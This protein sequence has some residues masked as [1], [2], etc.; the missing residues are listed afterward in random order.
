MLTIMFNSELY[1]QQTVSRVFCSLLTLILIFVCE[2][3]PSVFAMIHPQSALLLQRV[4]PIY[5]LI[6]SNHVFLPH[7]RPRHAFYC[8]AIIILIE[9]GLTIYS[10]IDSEYA[11]YV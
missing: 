8:T 9:T 7:A 11:G 6:L 5:F 4:R 2:Y 1:L 10:R 3:S